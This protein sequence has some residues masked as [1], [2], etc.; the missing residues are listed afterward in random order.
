[1][2]RNNATLLYGQ[3]DEV[4]DILDQVALDESELRAALM[5]AFKRIDALEKSTLNRKDK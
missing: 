4:L 3:T 2:P 5:N 1:M